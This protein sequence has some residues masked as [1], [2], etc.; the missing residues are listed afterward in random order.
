MTDIP[1]ELKPA[2]PVRRTAV[3]AARAGTSLIWLVPILALVVTLG[4]AWNAYSGRGTLISVEFSDATGITPGETAL[5]FREITVGKVE[6]VRFTSDL[7]RVVVDIRVDKDIAG[8]IDSSAEFWIV[9][10]QVSAQ[11]I[12]RLDTVLTGAFI[13]GFWDDQSDDPQR[14]FVGLD[15]MPLTQIGQKGT[16]V[17]L[18]ADKAKGLTEGAP[19][20]FHGVQVGTLQN[21][22]L[23]KSDDVVLA[24]A[25]I[26]AP[27][28]QRLT[29]ATVFWNTSGFSV[30]FGPRGLALNV[31]SVASLIQGGVE[32]AT[33]TSGG[34][35]VSQGSVFSLHPDEATASAAVFTEDEEQAR[36]SLRIEGN[37]IGLERGADVRYMGLTVGS[38]TEIT[39]GLE[40]EADGGAGKVYQLVNLALTPSRLGLPAETTSQE[41]LDFLSRRVGKGLRARLASAGFFGRSMVIDLVDIA[42]AEPAVLDLAAEPY[43][44]MP[45]VEGDISDFG[46]T[47]QGFLSRIGELPIEELMKS[48]T[49]MMNSITAIASSDDTRAVPASVKAALDEIQ[50]AAQELREVTAELRE[51][52][53][54]GQVRGMIDEATLA[55]EAVK[56]AAADVPEMVDKIDAAAASVD[57]FDFDGISAEARSI[58]SDLRV[59]LASDDAEQLPRNLS[60]TLQAASGL[61]NDLRDGGAAG[62][63]NEALKSARVAADSIAGSTERLPDLTSRIEGLVTRADSAIAAYGNRSDFNNEALTT[64]RE[65]RRAANAFA[66]L[67]RMIERNP[68]AFIMGR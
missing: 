60:E 30:S 51:G 45:S 31:N 39:V 55:A 8:F 3:R 13:E 34:Q 38:V 42:D 17:V 19:I 64:M 37:V 7:A 21:L 29:T 5:K 16:W 15:R 47:A 59:M 14:N 50:S 41:T 26:R 43:P 57:E 53:A 44:L 65:M 22:R 49:D 27:H 46:D 68:R 62:S 11:G 23:G 33:L 18:S 32:F 12:S 20:T 61:L 40:P 4:L 10:P 54:V 35:P 6:A 63:L 9:R 1:P 56:L 67:M 25:F 36:I 52:G 24:D 66:S 48:G 28:D 58:L 2:H